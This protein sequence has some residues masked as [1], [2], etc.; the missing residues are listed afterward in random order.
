M[1][2]T[3]KHPTIIPSLTKSQGQSAANDLQYHDHHL[4]AYLALTLL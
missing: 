4:F 3:Y 1:G 2:T